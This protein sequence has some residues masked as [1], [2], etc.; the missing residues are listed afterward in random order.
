M[1]HFISETQK[2]LIIIIKEKKIKVI[3]FR[4]SARMRFFALL[5]FAVNLESTKFTKVS[6]VK[7]NKDNI[8]EN[9]SF[10]HLLWN[11]I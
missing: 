9:V 10:I 11:T 4:G 3:N 1:F 8:K 6:T 7:E 5:N 2:K